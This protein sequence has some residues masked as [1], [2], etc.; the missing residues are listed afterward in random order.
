MG[1]DRQ[2]KKLKS[3]KRV[4]SDRDQSIQYDGATT[5]QS[6]DNARKL[7]NNK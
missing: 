1:K 3:S 5:M 6:P 7:N 4:E 2:E